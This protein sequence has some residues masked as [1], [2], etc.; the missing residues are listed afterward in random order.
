MR[1]RNERKTLNHQITVALMPTEFMR[2]LTSGNVWGMSL[3]SEGAES[4]SGVEL[5]HDSI[6]QRTYLE[7]ENKLLYRIAI[8]Y[9]ERKRA[10]RKDSEC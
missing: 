8:V 5:S 3:F 4:L 2:K 10:R 1:E 9:G 7:E 6:F